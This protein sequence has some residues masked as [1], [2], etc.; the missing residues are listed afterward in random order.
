MAEDRQV[1]TPMLVYDDAPAA[2]DF[3]CRAFGFEER[4][5]FDMP[6]GKIGHAELSFG[7]AKIALATTW[8]EGGMASP[9]TLPAVH[10]Q[11]YCEVPDVDAHY[12][13]AKAE[14]ATIAEAPGEPSH[15][16]RTYRA[17][18]LEGHRW[19]FATPHEQE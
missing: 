1:I 9:W 3:L 16:S 19:V 14:G 15:G 2:M 13:R 8:T 6:D 10:S 11:V 17:L 5:R 7:G 12:E 4:S 18:D